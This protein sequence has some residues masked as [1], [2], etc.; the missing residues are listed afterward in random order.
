VTDQPRY[1]GVARP[2]Q[3]IDP[4]APRVVVNLTRTAVPPPPP[5]PST[6]PAPPPSTPPAPPAGSIPVVEPAPKPVRAAASHRRRL[7]RAI[8]RRW[9]LSVWVAVLGVASAL[10]VILV[11]TAPLAGLAGPESTSAFLPPAGPSGGPCIFEP[12]Q[13]P[14][15]TGKPTLVR[16]PTI[17]VQSSLEDLVLDSQRKLTPPKRYE[18][19]GWWSEGVPPG[20]VGPSVIAGHV[21]SEQGPAVFHRLHELQPGDVVE[22]ERGGQVVRFRVYLK[23]VY[24]KDAF[25]TDKVYQPTPDAELRLITCGGT[26]DSRRL[27]YRDNVVIYA[28]IA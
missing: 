6:L 8:V 10:V 21:D 23:E 22:V 20:D 12:C 28:V 13:R 9:E 16:I 17:G 11:R 26:F 24:P 5:P 19:A 7:R 25:P 15:L 27:S 14:E 1:I 2:P 18:E 4:G 3:G